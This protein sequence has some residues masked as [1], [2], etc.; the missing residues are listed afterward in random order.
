M[1]F[2]LVTKRHLTTLLCKVKIVVAN[3]H[4]VGE[5][6]VDAQIHWVHVELHYNKAHDLDYYE[7]CELLEG[8]SVCDTPHAFLYCSDLLLNFTNMF[9]CGIGVN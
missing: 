8:E 6:L 4:P 3:E 5:F 9:F 7:S 2:A 1:N